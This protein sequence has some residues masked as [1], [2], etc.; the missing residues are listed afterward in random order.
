MTSSN[1]EEDLSIQS[2]SKDMK[3]LLGRQ[4]LTKKWLV[5]IGVLVAYSILMVIPLVGADLGEGDMFEIIRTITASKQGTLA[6]L[7]ILPVLTAGLLMYLSLKINLYKL[8]IESE[9]ERNRYNSVRIILSILMTIGM[10]FLIVVSGFYG[11]DLNILTQVFII[12]QLTIA[13]VLISV[14]IELINRGWGL[15]SGISLFL[16]VG[17]SI[18]LTQG[19]IAPNNILE[20]PNDV[21]SAR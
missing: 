13:G 7:G 10:A 4:N 20:G 5:T 14:L 8:N 9:K 18:R 2:F 3:E 16:I 11:A 21:T 17:I 15:G 1:P 6:E 12:L 19:F